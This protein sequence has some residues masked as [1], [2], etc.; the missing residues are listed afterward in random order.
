MIEIYRIN[1][2]LTKDFMGRFDTIEEARAYRNHAPE[3]AFSAV[4]VDGMTVADVN[5]AITSRMATDPRACGCK[6]ADQFKAEKGAK[7]TPV[8]L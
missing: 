8:E 5:G 2:N 7:S 1:P 6:I 3:V 4:S